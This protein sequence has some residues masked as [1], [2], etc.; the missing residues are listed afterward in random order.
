MKVQAKSL[1]GTN[2]LKR[3]FLPFS[4]GTIAFFCKY[5]CLLFLLHFFIKTYGKLITKKMRVKFR[6]ICLPQSRLLSFC[7]TETH[8]NIWI[9]MKT[10]ENRLWEL[11]DNTNSFHSRSSTQG[12]LDEVLNMKQNWVHK[13]NLEILMALVPVWE[14]DCL[15]CISFCSMFNSQSAREEKGSICLTLFLSPLLQSYY[16][17]DLLKH[18]SCETVFCPSKQ[19]SRLFRECS[20]LQN[21]HFQKT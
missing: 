18:T 9:K 1:K 15:S 20:I 13:I 17:Q 8:T 5:K 21:C 16:K 14:Y 4:S 11:I 2:H 10:T 6:T 7:H 3:S 12:S 19:C